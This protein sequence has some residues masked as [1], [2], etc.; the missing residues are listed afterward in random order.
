MGGGKGEGE[1]ERGAGVKRDNSN[2]KK[3]D[4]E[5]RN[6]ACVPVAAQIRS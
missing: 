2:D 5:A 1:E 4:R 6:A 3:E